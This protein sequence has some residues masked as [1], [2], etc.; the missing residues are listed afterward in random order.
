MYIHVFNATKLDSWQWLMVRTCRMVKVRFRDI[1]GVW[2]WLE[3]KAETKS[4]AETK[5]RN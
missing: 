2:L 1:L 3:V 4:G 5:G